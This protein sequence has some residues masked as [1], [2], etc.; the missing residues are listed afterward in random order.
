[1]LS[2]KCLHPGATLQPKDWGNKMVLTNYQ[3]R[4]AGA[5]SQRLESPA[6]SEASL[7][8]LMLDCFAIQ[9]VFTEAKTTVLAVHCAK[10]W[11]HQEDGSQVWVYR[12]YTHVGMA[13]H[14]LSMILW[15]HN[16]T[17]FPS[18]GFIAPLHSRLIIS[19]P[20]SANSSYLFC[21]HFITGSLIKLY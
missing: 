8:E 5:V 6:H 20:L 17:T 9:R 1:M 3:Q 14:P 12:H 13:F 21:C 16:F 2:T 4:F 10:R 11:W 19:L 7:E 15:P 18:L